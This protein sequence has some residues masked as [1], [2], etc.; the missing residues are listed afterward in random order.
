[1]AD[2]IGEVESCVES[3]RL[4]STGALASLHHLLP[5]EGG[6]GEGGS[7]GGTEGSG[8]VG[9]DSGLSLLDVA[10][11]FVLAFRTG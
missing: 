4:Q 7:I 6:I 11:G 5:H 2:G 10:D 1:M 8:N 3:S 9:E